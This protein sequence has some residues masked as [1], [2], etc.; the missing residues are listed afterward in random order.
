MNNKR[1]KITLPKEEHEQIKR[2]AEFFGMNV[3]AYIRKMAADADT[4]SLNF[5]SVEEH[6]KYLNIQRR[7]VMELIYTIIKTGDYTPADLEYILKNSNDVLK[8]QKKFLMD[9]SKEAE[10]KKKVISNKVRNIL[11]SNKKRNE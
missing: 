4:I 7:A 5:K 1:I 3:S 8:S 6:T 2:N 10:W 9:F 11:K